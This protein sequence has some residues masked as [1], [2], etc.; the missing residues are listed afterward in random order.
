MTRNSARARDEPRCAGDGAPLVSVNGWVRRVW[1][2]AIVVTLLGLAGCAGVQ[3]PVGS[4]PPLP[5]GCVDEFS[6]YL[7]RGVRSGCL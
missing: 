7:N 4:A 6:G 2:G 3:A 5:P 1:C